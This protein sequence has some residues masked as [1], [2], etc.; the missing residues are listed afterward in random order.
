MAF[1]PET[2]GWTERVNQILEQYLWM[3]VSYNQD[4]CNIW[5]THTAFSHKN[6]EHQSTMQ[7]PFSTIYERN[8]SFDTIHIS[9]DS[10]AGKL[11]TELQS[12][13]Q[14]VKEQL[15]LEIR[16]FNKYADRNWTT[17]PY[18][19]PGDK[20]WL[21]SKNIKTSRHSKKVSKMMVGTL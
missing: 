2:N 16:L 17:P 9:Q 10:P 1:Q 12:V 21:A 7:S 19:Q 6:A 14:V 5:I 4:D 20:G 3:Y 18:F 13:Q 15:K 8:P 11:S